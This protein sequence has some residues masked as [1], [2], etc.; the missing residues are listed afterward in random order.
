MKQIPENAILQYSDIGCHFNINGLNRL[1]E[2]I[3]LCEKIIFLHFNI[4]DLILVP[5]II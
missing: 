5:L 4:K 1:K 2:Y 3:G